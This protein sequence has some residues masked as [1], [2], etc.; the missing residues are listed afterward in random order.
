MLLSLL[1]MCNDLSDHRWPSTLLQKGFQVH[2]IILAH[3]D[4]INKHVR[5]SRSAVRIHSLSAVHIHPQNCQKRISNGAHVSCQV[6]KMVK[7]ECCR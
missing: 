3:H 6:M 2:H 7:Y 4:E 1:H 5:K